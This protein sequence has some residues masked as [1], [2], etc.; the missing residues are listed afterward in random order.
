MDNYI[1]TESLILDT[2]TDAPVVFEVNN[3][4]YSIYPPTL[5]KTLLIDRLKRK[6][7]INSECSKAAPLEEALRVCEENKE[8]VLQLLAYC[9]LRLKEEVQ[10]EACIKER[11]SV[12]SKLEADELATLLL[13][14]ISDTT[15]SDLIK[16]FGIDRD[17]ENRRKI[18]QVKNSNNTVAFGGHSIWGTLIDFACERYGWSFDYVMWEISYNNLLML[19][20]DR[21]DSAYLTDEERKKAH[22]KHIG[23]VINADDPANMAKI[24]AMRWD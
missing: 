4:K 19:F 18:A 5:G 23:T 1:N 22:L 3:K 21:P 7:S 14:V 6:L 2:L 16:H 17:N 24:K 15:V 13:T 9:T 11:I 12:L 8:I 20:N 10:N